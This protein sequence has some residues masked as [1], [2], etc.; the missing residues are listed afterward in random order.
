MGAAS[1]DPLTS[2]SRLLTRLPTMCRPADTAVRPVGNPSMSATFTIGLLGPLQVTVDGR[3]RA[4]SGVLQRRLLSALALHANRIVSADALCDALWPDRLP[5]DHHAALHTHL[6]RLRKLLP[7]GTI[8]RVAAGYRL[9]VDQEAL[10]TDRFASAVTTAAAERSVDPAASATRLDDALALW[11]GE[12][13]DEVADLDDAVIEAERLGELRARA[14]E[15]RADCLLALGRHREVL[16]DLD[17]FASR[18]PLRERAQ[19][20]LMTALR[21]EGRIADALGVYERYRVALADELGIDPSARLRALHDDIVTGVD[22]TVAPP[23][24]SGVG[25]PAPGPAA[26]GTAAPGPFGGPSPRTTRRTPGP[27]R[28]GSSFVGRHELLG[29]IESLLADHRI[30]TLLG[31]GGVGK[32]RLAHELSRR[33]DGDHPDGVWFCALASADPASAAATVAMTLDIEDRGDVDPVDRI[34]DVLRQQRA[35]LVLDNCEHVLDAAA[36]I[37]E[38]VAAN[39]PGVTVVATSRERLA[40]DGEQ[41]CAVPPLPAPRRGHPDEP[42]VRLFLDRAAAVRPQWR[43]DDTE[44]EVVAEI[45]RH[46]DG[47]PLAIE[48]AAARLH[49]L[50][51]D[52]IA[53]GLGRRLDLLTGGR[54]TSDRHRSLHAAIS[55]SV[56]MLADDERALLAAVS[57][58]QGPFT[59]AGAAAVGEVD[60]AT[61]RSLLSSLVERSLLQRD[62]HRYTMLESLREYGAS[63]LADPRAAEVRDR[64]AAFHRRFVL[65]SGTRLRRAREVGVLEDLDASIADLRAAFGHLLD[66]EMVADALDFAVALRD[67]GFYRMRPEVL[68]WAGLAADAALGAG[69]AAGVDPGAVSEACAVAAVSAWKQGDIARADE[70][71]ARAGALAGDAPGMFLLDLR[72]TLSLIHGDLETT[73]DVSRRS[74]ALDRTAG[75]ELRV[76]EA[77]GMILLAEGYLG[78]PEVA[79]HAEEYLAS[80]TPESPLAPAAWA[81]YCAGEAVLDLDPALASRRLLRAMELSIE[82]GTSFGLGVAGTTYASLAARHGD[83]AVAIREYRWLL[84]HWRRAGVRSLYLTSMRSVVELLARVGADRAAATLLGFVTSDA[85][86]HDVFGADAVR[87]AELV[88]QLTDRLGADAF[89]E[90]GALGAGLDDHSAG[91]VATAAF[92]EV[93]GG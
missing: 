23:A 74:L 79:A 83:P 31:P 43:P 76:L 45:C 7:D 1:A 40:V 64:H 2:R 47:L 8:E 69:P 91:A 21:H 46:L 27:A 44:L 66:R 71:A 92:D 36:A 26:P 87:R 82:S 52:E 9:V 42:A 89:A 93:V 22:E 68:G 41:L 19:A 70:L 37:A 62:G 50:T 15:E 63:L 53:A 13:F 84:P 78:R 34:A 60:V 59:V 56:D 38:A 4:P 6:F 32:T 57:Q 67:Y 88:A 12:P 55:W 14:I 80:L 5:A 48:L 54:R 85:G 65:D 73:I 58:F 25:S 30:V 49:T 3:D 77:G 81:W 28:L 20:L 10:D 86:G 35:V 18:H 51:L 75:D 29:D 33:I 72:G 90:A 61:A 39:A 24:A 16:A 11:R 17:A